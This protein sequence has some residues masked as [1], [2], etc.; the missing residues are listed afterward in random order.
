M[1]GRVVWL[2]TL[3]VFLCGDARAQKVD[4]IRLRNGD[5]ITCEISQLSHGTLAIS[6]DPLGK[7][8]VHWGQ[9]ESI[10]S[11]RAFD[12]QLASGERYYGA[13]AAAAP[14]QLTITLG[15]GLSV[16]LALA[17]VVQLAPIGRSFWK[18]VDGTLDIGFS[19]AQANLET[20]GTANGSMTYR[21]RRASHR[22][23]SR[24]PRI[25]SSTTTS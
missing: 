9:I 25:S 21:S 23:P 7:V 6:A 20:R 11:P 15:G 16:T 22:H 14:N 12:L 5:R 8:S 1:S 19:F 13:L 4:V 18:R 2:C 10:E 17:D 24:R 3:I